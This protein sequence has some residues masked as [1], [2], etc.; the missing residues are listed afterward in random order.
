MT[1]AD[2]AP[3]FAEEGPTPAAF[4]DDMLVLPEW[5][6]EDWRKLFAD[7]A[8]QPFRTSEILIRRGAEAR[9][10]YFV[11]AGTVE[12]GIST[13]EGVSVA[14]LA[15]IGAKSVI[16]EQSFFDGQPRSANVWAVT[17]GVLLR[18]EFEQ[19]RHFGAGEPRLARD[20]LFA[21]GGILSARLRGTVGAAR[22]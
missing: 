5:R 19:Y 3:A 7:T 21:L 17:D 1:G 10:L 11:A 22:R 4:V 16:G 6:I 20:L 14:S 8:I 18:W 13:F 2:Y 9:A 12:V 15:R